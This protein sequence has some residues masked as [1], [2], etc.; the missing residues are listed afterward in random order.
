MTRENG[1]ETKSSDLRH[2]AEKR[3]AELQTAS[4]KQQDQSDN[5]KL[6]HELQVHQI[7]LQMQNE[8]LIRTREELDVSLEKYSDLYDF[9]P[10]GYFTLSEDDIIL[11][12]NF[13]GAVLLGEHCTPLIN[14]HFASF[15]SPETRS[16]FYEFLHKVL[17]C[18]VTKTCELV[19]TGKDNNPKNVHV[20]AVAYGLGGNTGRKCLMVILDITER[21][22]IALERDRLILELN[23]ALEKIKT[24]SGLLP[25]CSYCKKIRDDQGY[26]NQLESYISKHSEAVFSHSICPE[27]Y[28]KEISKI[29]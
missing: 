3:L 15:V 8:E 22:R 17:T 1:K 6:I 10:I 16:I 27:C 5:L 4:G 14:R 9:A 2:C 26:W 25:I 24:L 29:K 13:T 23:Q 19:L 7:E 20:E 12:L 18:N 11:E 28:N 21:I